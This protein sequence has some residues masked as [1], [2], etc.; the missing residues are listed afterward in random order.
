MKSPTPTAANAAT[1]VTN[2]AEAK[3][4]AA[5]RK[6]TERAIQSAGPNTNSSLKSAVQREPRV[7]LCALAARGFT[8]AVIVARSARRIPV[9][10]AQAGFFDGHESQHKPS[11][12][13]AS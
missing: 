5:P 6:S 12:P 10:P 7:T 2:E 4:S 1:S 8:E 11:Q 13:S 3:Q 9:E